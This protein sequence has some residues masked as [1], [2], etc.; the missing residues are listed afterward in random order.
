MKKCLL[1]IACMGVYTANIVS[2]GVD[3][4]KKNLSEMTSIVMGAHI[5]AFSVDD[6]FAKPLDADGVKVWHEAI[7]HVHNY[8]KLNAK[9]RLGITTDKNL[10]NALHTIEQANFELVKHIRKAQK[11]ISNNAVVTDCANEF[12]RIRFQMADLAET[13]KMMS[14]DSQHKTDA[15]N[16]LYTLAFTLESTAIAAENHIYKYLGKGQ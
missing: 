15:Q 6:L 8:V 9:N 12:S 16:L 13:I 2:S 4:K 1:L 5:R 7:N 14:F 10:M 11:S 3:Y